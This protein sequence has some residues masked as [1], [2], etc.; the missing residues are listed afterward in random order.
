MSWECIY[1][2]KKVYHAEKM[3]FDGKI[4][5]ANCHAKWAAEQKATGKGAWGGTYD[6]AA[7]VQPAYYRTADN[8][9]SARME[10]GAEYKG[11]DDN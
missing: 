8:S 11:E 7:D 9:G 2:T 1:C 5:H 4:F 6:K 3:E 10:S